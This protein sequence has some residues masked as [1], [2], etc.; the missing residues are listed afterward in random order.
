LGIKLLARG[1]DAH[2]SDDVL[3]CASKKNMQKLKNYKKI[4]FSIRFN[5][6]EPYNQLSK[7]SFKTLELPPPLGLQYLSNDKMPQEA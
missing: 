3:L 5:F 1:I 6:V 4:K 2:F 7:P